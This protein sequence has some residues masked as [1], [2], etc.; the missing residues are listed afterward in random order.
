M[1]QHGHLWK[2]SIQAQQDE[3]KRQPGRKLVENHEV[4]HASRCEYFDHTKQ[5][6]IRALPRLKASGL[7]GMVKTD[8]KLKAWRR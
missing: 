6:V 8:G 5:Q 7:V 4:N 3:K 1:S 2:R